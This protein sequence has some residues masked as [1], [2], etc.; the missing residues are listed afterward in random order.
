MPP[1]L[2]HGGAAIPMNG[3]H[4]TRMSNRTS[5]RPFIFSLR[6]YGLLVGDQ[7]GFQQDRAEKPA[8]LSPCIGT[9]ISAFMHSVFGGNYRLVLTRLSRHA[10]GSNDH[11]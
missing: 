10:Q 3:N 6:M 4:M 11:P 8:G 9:V 2:K 5:P 7:A 1:R